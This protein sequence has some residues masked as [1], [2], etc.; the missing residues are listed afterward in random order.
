MVI[1]LINTLNIWKKNGEM[2]FDKLIRDNMIIPEITSKEREKLEELH[3]FVNLSHEHKIVLWLWSK[4][5]TTHM[6]KIMNNFDFVLF[7][8]PNRSRS[9][10]MES[11]S[12]K[13]ISMLN[14]NILI[15]SIKLRH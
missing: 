12:L 13:I 5:G 6:S 8:I 3:Y 7:L 1:K 14:F 10:F 4:C 2:E 15:L 9:N 11:N